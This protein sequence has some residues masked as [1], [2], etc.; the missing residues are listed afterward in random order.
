MRDHYRKAFRAFRGYPTLHGM[1]VELSARIAPRGVVALLIP[2]PVADLNG[3]RFVRRALSESHTVQEP[4]LELGQDAFASVTQ[5]CFAL[6]ARPGARPGDDPERPFVLSERRRAL[7]TA[8]AL[9]TPPALERAAP[10]APTSAPT[11]RH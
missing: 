6:V 7:E 4:L 5:P 8:T 2:S 1:F 11:L 9:C 3:Y 10:I